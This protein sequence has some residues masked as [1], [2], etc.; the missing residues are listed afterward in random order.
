[1]RSVDLVFLVAE[2]QAQLPRRAAEIV[3]LR[4][5]VVVALY[6]AVIDA[7]RPLTRAIPIVAVFCRDPVA[8]GY[9]TRWS[10]PTRNIRGILDGLD[11]LCGKRVELLHELLP[12]ARAI[13]LIYE[14]SISIHRVVLERTQ[15]AAHA[16]GLE[17]RP[18]PVDDVA[19]LVQIP[20][21]AAA[22]AAA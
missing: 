1:G 19:A 18:Y 12:M 4:P 15:V 22:D 2:G 9:S 14:P 11:T 20:A 13:G 6:P 21:R 16:R 5:D 3:A 7:L 10:R 8:L 17:L